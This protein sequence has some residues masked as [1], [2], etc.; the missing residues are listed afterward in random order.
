MVTPA[1]FG[2]NLQQGGTGFLAHQVHGNLAWPDD[3]T[4]PLLSAHPF[5]INIV[6]A[7]NTLQNL[8]WRQICGRFARAIDVFERLSCHAYRKRGIMQRGIGKHTIKRTF[9]LAYTTAF[10]ARNKFNHRSGHGK[11]ERLG[12][13]A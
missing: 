11:A 6:I 3:L 7:T 9:K 1:Q 4:L 12:L 5:D 8:G 13:G 10:R 2:A